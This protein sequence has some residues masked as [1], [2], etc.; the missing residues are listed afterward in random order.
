MT[1]STSPVAVNRTAAIFSQLEL[2]GMPFPNIINGTNANNILFGT[3]ENDTING[4]GGNDFIDGGAGD[5]ILNGGTGD[6]RLSQVQGL[7]LLMQGMVMI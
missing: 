1:E 3:A 2:V 4:L 5:D 6:D 7:I